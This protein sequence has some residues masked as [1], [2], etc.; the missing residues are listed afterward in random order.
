MGLHLYSLSQNNIDSAGAEAIADALRV[1]KTI[2][3]VE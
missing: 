3:T 2:N 1:N